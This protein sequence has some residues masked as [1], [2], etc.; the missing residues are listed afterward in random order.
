MA[1]TVK[2]GHE[3]ATIDCVLVTV[4]TNDT[5]TEIALDT[6]NNVQVTVGSETTDAVKLIIKGRLIAQKPEQTVVTGNS[7]VITDNVFNPEL[8]EILQGGNVQYDEDGSFKSYTPPVAGAD[9][10]VT[11]FTL[12]V[13]SAIYGADALIKGYE[14]I[15]YPNCQGVPVALSSQDGTFR[16]PEYTINSAP[17]VGQAPYKLE[18]V[19]SLPEVQEATSMASQLAI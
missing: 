1:D 16:A 13:Y 5:D 9:T 19:Q 12:N 17:D 10:D 8:V 14:K 6:A 15:S 7:I 11:P 3:I 2:R 18:I 4:K